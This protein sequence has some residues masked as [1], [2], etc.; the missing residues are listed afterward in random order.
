MV[1]IY[2]LV[3]F[4]RGVAEFQISS[5]CEYEKNHEFFLLFSLFL[6]TSFLLNLKKR[7]ED[8]MMEKKLI[9]EVKINIQ[10]VLKELKVLINLLG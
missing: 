5:M 7:L 2:Q 1:M 4:K 8:I 10:V 9:T 6:K 3:N